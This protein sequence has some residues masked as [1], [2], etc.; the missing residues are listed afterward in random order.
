MN[1]PT[2]QAPDYLLGSKAELLQDGSSKGLFPL[3]VIHLLE[4]LARIES[5][6]QARLRGL[7]QEDKE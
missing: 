6:R 7:A 5:R 3:E 2:K 1:S 4:V